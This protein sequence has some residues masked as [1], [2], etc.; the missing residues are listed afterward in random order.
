MVT[1]AVPESWRSDDSSRHD[2]VGISRLRSPAGRSERV[3]AG[4]AGRRCATLH[5][6]VVAMVAT[7]L[8]ER[9][10]PGRSGDGLS[11]CGLF[12]RHDDPPNCGDDGRRSIKPMTSGSNPTS[13]GGRRCVSLGRKA[14]RSSESVVLSD[15]CDRANRLVGRRIVMPVLFRGPVPQR[16]FASR[17]PGCVCLQKVCARE[18][19]ADHARHQS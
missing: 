7:R 14:N 3:A 10:A 11:D 17:Q 19:T 9:K 15:A 13:S 12:V 1:R 5:H 6:I 16:H 18:L 4:Q 8:T 2:S